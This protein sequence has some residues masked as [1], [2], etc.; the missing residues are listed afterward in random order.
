MRCSGPCAV[1]GRADA[2]EIKVAGE[3]VAARF[4]RLQRWIEERPDRDE[5]ARRRRRAA[6]HCQPH[7]LQFVVE[8]RPLDMVD[9]QHKAISVLAL[10]AQLD[11]AGDSHARGGVTQH[12]MRDQRRPDGG[13]GEAAGDRGGADRD[14]ECAVAAP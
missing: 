8:P 13:D 12:G 3:I 14:D 2:L 9:A 6:L 11:I 4:E 7:A 10:L 5:A 1:G